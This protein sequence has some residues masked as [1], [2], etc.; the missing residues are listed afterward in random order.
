MQKNSMIRK[1]RLISTFI[2]WQPGKQTIAIH[3]L[4]SD[5]EIGSV[6]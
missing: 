2:M 3:I 6:T 4:K 5:N 1:I